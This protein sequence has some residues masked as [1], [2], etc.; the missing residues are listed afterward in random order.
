LR[1]LRKYVEALRMR[2]IDTDCCIDELIAY[3]DMHHSL[4]YSVVLVWYYSEIVFK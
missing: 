2:A 1:A 3:A 4:E